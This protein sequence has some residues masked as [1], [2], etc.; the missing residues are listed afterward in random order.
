MSGVNTVT[1]EITGEEITE[2]QLVGMLKSA[3][4]MRRDA[5]RTKKAYEQVKAAFG[6]W[7]DTHPGERLYDAETRTYAALKGG[8]DSQVLDVMTLAREEPTALAKL[9]ELGLLKLDVTA[10]KVQKTKFQEGAI[11]ERYIIKEPR[12]TRLIVDR[13]EE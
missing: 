6:D 8:G 13:E 10:F 3:Y 12:T 1:G 9:A 2:R 4:D 7:L 5:A 11:V